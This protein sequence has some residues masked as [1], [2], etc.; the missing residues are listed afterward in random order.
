MQV[1]RPGL[2]GVLATT[3]AAAALA[4]LPAPSVAA[5]PRAAPLT[6]TL[7]GDA[8]AA[9]VRANPATW[10]VGARPSP[11]AARLAARHGARRVVPG[12]FSVARAAARGLAADLRRHGLL[13][14]AEPDR[15]QARPLQAPAD[16]LSPFATWRTI[17][18][19]DL[20]PP[21]VG[22]DSPLIAIVDTPVDT[23]HP[24]VAGSNIAISGA[25]APYSLH[26]T[27]T[28]TVA[29]APANGQGT[30]GVWPGARVLNVPLSP[31]VYCSES[32]R[33]IRAAV[34]AGAAVL[35]M[36]YGSLALCLSEYVAIQSAV[37]AGVIPVAAVGN[38]YEDGNP[39]EFPASLPHVLS[40]AATGAADAPASFSNRNGA[41]DLAAPGQAVLTGI[42]AAFDTKDGIADGY[43]SVAGTSFASPMIAAAAAWVRQARPELS[44]DQVGEVI[45]HGARDVGAAGWDPAT[46]WGVLSLAGSLAAP[47]PVADSAEPN[48]DIAF[49]DGRA[50]GKAEPA[51]YTGRTRALLSGRLDQYEDPSDVYRLRIPPRS[52]VRIVLRPSAGD[53]DLWVLGARAR[54]ITSSLVLGHS[55]ARGTGTEAVTVRNRTRRTA[56]AYVLAGIDSDVTAVSAIYSLS[57]RARSS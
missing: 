30:V 32:A 53:P 33:G 23:T 37:R 34:A 52:G 51:I 12:T 8:S 17:V 27:A 11:V 46:G 55:D 36:S 14:F 57:V 24:D 25:M 18:A 5:R 21:A 7:P 41:V 20:T 49:V 48:D 39:A 29:A 42:P 2:L 50:F 4:L 19:G 45:R 13:L 56:T 35:N 15:V 28:A 43:A 38:E 9:A 31:K 26:G 47:A 16:P 40:A 6:V 10:L 54:S 22:A 3:A 44:P 1:T